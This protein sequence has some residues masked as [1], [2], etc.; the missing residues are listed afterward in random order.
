MAQ[1]SSVFGL[2]NTSPTRHSAVE[3]LQG[4]FTGSLIAALGLYFL[5]SAGLL[6]GST[7]GVAFLLH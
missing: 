6:T 2:W 7:A 5:A 4:I 1:I 3:D